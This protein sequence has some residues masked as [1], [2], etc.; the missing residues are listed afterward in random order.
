MN[1]RM[2]LFATYRS[3]VFLTVEHKLSAPMGPLYVAH[4]LNIPTKSLTVLG[5]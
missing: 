1:D 3:S 5:W 2:N 4:T